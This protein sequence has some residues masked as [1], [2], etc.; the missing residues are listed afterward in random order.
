MIP[1]YKAAMAKYMIHSKGHC[2]NACAGFAPLSKFAAKLAP[3]AT[4][5]DINQK[6]L[7]IACAHVVHQ[8]LTNITAYSHCEIS[9]ITPE[10]I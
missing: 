2:F 5:H 4:V 9:T 1:E 8:G 6:T 3:T 7:T 10:M